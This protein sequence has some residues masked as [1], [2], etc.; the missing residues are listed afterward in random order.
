MNIIHIYI[1]FVI[2]VLIDRNVLTNHLSLKL[3]FD[4]QYK[5]LILKSK[6]NSLLSQ[7]IIFSHK[8][9][10]RLGVKHQS[11]VSK[12]GLLLST[13]GVFCYLI[14]DFSQGLRF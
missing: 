10:F 12:K 13:N 9:I 14:L 11:I 6:I 5:H 1:Y 4:I 7:T 8:Y 2:N 3:S